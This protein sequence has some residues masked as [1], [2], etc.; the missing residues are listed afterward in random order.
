MRS[1]L[2][3][4]HLISI[5]KREF[6]LVNDMGCLIKFFRPFKD[7]NGKKEIK[8]LDKKHE[9]E[10]KQMQDGGMDAGQV[11]RFK[12]TKRKKTM[13]NLRKIAI[14]NNF[15]NVTSRRGSRSRLQMVNCFDCK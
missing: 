4:I 14:T 10:V 13:S 7:E 3:L 2:K 1:K 5:E 9:I 11:G 15:L 6:N 12:A 8:F